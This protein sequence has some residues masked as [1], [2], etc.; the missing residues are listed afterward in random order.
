MT[1]PAILIRS[2]SAE[3]TFRN[4]Y[5]LEGGGT[6]F[7]DGMVLEISMNGGPFQDIVKA[8]GTF[9]R[10][11]YNASLEYSSNPLAS[12]NAWSGLSAGSS[13]NPAYI[14]TEVLLPPLANGKSVRFKWIVGCD[15]SVIASG[16]AGARIDGVSVTNDTTIESPNFAPVVDDQTFG[17]VDQTTRPNGRVVGTV[18]AS[19]SNGDQTLTYT[20]TAGNELGAFAL[21]AAT[22]QITVANSALV[23][24]LNHPVFTL[25]VQVADNGIPV[26]SDTA[27]ITI[28]VRQP[29]ATPVITGQTTLA[30]NEESGLTIQLSNLMVS[31]PDSP[32]YPAGFT[33]A[34]GDGSNYVRTGDTI[35]PATDFIG[36]LTVPVVVSD[37]ETD[38]ATF[39]LQVTVNPVNDAPSFQ[40]GA[41]VQII[42]NG[43][44]QTIGNWATNLSTGPADESGQMLNFTVTT[45]DDSF[46]ASLPTVSETGTLSFTAAAGRIG[47]VNVSVTLH[48]NGGTANGGVDSSGAQTFAIISTS[49]ANDPPSFIVGSDQAAAQDAGPQ[50]VV[51]FAAEI[52]PGPPDEA[53]Q[54]VNFLV[55]AADPTLFDVPPAIS[56]SGTL[57]YTPKATANG[58]TSVTVTLRDSGGT[59]NPGD[60]DTSDPQTFNISITTFTG[61]DGTYNGLALPALDVPP[62]ADKTGLVT[63]KFSVKG[64]F[65]GKLSLGGSSFSLKGTIDNAGRMRFGKTLDPT[66][67]LVRKDLPPLVLTLRMDVAGDSERVVGTITR[68]T[69][70]LLSNVAA[71]RALYASKVAVPPYRLVPADLVG[72][73]TVVFEQ[74]TAPLLLPSAF[75]QGDGFGTL[76]VTTKGVA[77]LKGELADGSKF[78]YANTLSK[79]NIWPLWKPFFKGQGAV[80]GYVQFRP[81]P[82]V[83]DLDGKDLLWFKP[84]DLKKTYYPGGWSKGIKTTLSGA[85]FAPSETL[86]GSFFS[87]APAPLQKTAKLVL[88]G[89]NFS[90]PS[91][92]ILSFDGKKITVVGDPDFKV[93]LTPNSGLFKGSFVHPFSHKKASFQGVVL[94]SQGTASGYFFGFNQAGLVTITPDP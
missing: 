22:G 76:E 36:T 39:P 4:L 61:R 62:E 2:G 21:N 10:G 30:T 48:D 92:K 11:G 8:G 51:N 31:D 37:G 46:F 55:S 88:T 45:S 50:T 27:T 56:P 64:S 19:D 59:A 57:T 17:I 84:Q 90:A 78:T 24:Y 71:D 1:T 80:T 43:A 53:S 23:D 49:I 9:L 68:D 65:T 54:T 58:T 85:H 44:P 32:G 91:T 5:N 7:W 42:A 47:V 52:S 73:Y 14:T 82:G 63:L 26:L 29:G 60:D 89:G 83:S 25:T 93:S 67:L 86:G 15:G 12:R 72:K 40:A 20:F 77:K 18:A 35:T 16:S 69:G 6:V 28:N 66:M 3:L 41:D 74:P 38:S 33:L 87:T 79:D 13:T 34:V 94:Q 75:P 81:V 70:E